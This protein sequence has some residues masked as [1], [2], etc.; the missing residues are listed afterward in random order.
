LYV[1]IFEQIYDS[2]VAEDYQVRIVFQDFLVLA[3]EDGI[4]DVTPEAI[5]RRTNVPLD[6][7][8]AGIQKLE[9]PDP[10]SRTKECEGRRLIRLDDHR[11]WGWRIVNYLKYRAIRKKEDRTDYHREYYRNHRSKSS[12]QG[13]PQQSSTPLNTTQPIQPIAEAEAEAKEEKYSLS[14]V[15]FASDPEPAY[16][17]EPAKPKLSDDQ[18]LVGLT[19]KHLYDNHKSIVRRGNPGEIEDALRLI[20]KAD[21]RPV[22]TVM[23]HIRKQHNLWLSSDSWKEEK[24]VHGLPKWLEKG[25]WKKAPQSD[26]GGNAA[27]RRAG[28]YDEHW[29]RITHQEILDEGAIRSTDGTI[30]Y[31]DGRVAPPRLEEGRVVCAD[32]RVLHRVS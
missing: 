4:V 31:P 26:G 18:R 7:V 14:D 15:P 2:S 32:G 23:E 9:Q 10:Q 5:A 22:P 17:P 24:Y 16:V 21:S 3:D 13:D 27:P 20:A 29:N 28:L 6:I 1:K 19:A 30:R 12:H 11:D 8:R 25:T